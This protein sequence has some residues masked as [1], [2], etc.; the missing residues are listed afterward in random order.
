ME[1]PDCDHD[2]CHPQ[3][4][5]SRQQGGNREAYHSFEEKGVEGEVGDGYGV[6]AGIEMSSSLSVTPSPVTRLITCA[7]LSSNSGLLHPSGS[8]P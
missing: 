7:T 8:S 3:K 6:L 1:A 4:F 2:K 5:S